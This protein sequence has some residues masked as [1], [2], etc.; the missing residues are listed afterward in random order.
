MGDNL[1]KWGTITNERFE[2]LMNP[3]IYAILDP[4]HS[5]RT[6]ASQAIKIAW[7]HQ[8]KLFAA[9]EGGLK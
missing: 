7:I 1:D 2:V 3:V 5:R 8:I 9:G 6:T 4:N